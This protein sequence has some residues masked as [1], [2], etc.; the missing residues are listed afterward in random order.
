MDS[1]RIFMDSGHDWNTKIWDIHDTLMY[2]IAMGENV[3]P[4]NLD[5]KPMMPLKTTRLIRM[6]LAAWRIFV[7]NS[8]VRKSGSKLT[9]NGKKM[10]LH[11]ES[12][13]LSWLVVWNIKFIFP[14]ILG[15]IIPIDFHIFQRGG[16]TTNQFKGVST[17]GGAIQQPRL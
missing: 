3:R 11:Q 13:H 6:E 8:W 15:I 7:V 2:A 1:D 4:M 17:M 12:E 9:K 10:E 5:D 14:E 16:P